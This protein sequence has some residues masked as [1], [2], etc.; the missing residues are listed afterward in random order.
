MRSATSTGSPA[1]SDRRWSQYSLSRPLLT[2]TPMG[3]I[4]VVGALGMVLFV[5]GYA[6][7]SQ[8]GTLILGVLLAGTAVNYWARPEPTVPDETTCCPEPP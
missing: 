7:R 5:V 8:V 2:T 4:V 1:S 3:E 6:T